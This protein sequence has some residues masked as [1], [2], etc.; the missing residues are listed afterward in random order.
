M[1]PNNQDQLSSV[2]YKQILGKNSAKRVHCSTELKPY[3]PLTQ[4]LTYSKHRHNSKQLREDQ[5]VVV[6]KDRGQW[7]ALAVILLRKSWKVILHLR[8][9]ETHSSPLL[10]SGT[11]LECCWYKSLILFYFKITFVLWK[12]YILAHVQQIPHPVTR[13]ITFCRVLLTNWW[14]WAW[15]LSFREHACLYVLNKHELRRPVTVFF[16]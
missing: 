6:L 11:A 16:S 12:I 15:F 2:A 10:S 8:A 9:W 3:Y 1:K 13:K 7:W 14:V 4:T 5:G